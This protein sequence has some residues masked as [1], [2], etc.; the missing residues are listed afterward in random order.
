M[1][2]EEDMV[3]EEE[4]PKVKPDEHIANTFEAIPTNISIGTIVEKT[5]SSKFFTE[6]KMSKKGFPQAKR[7][8][9]IF[10]YMFIVNYNIVLCRCQF[11]ML[12]G[13]YFHNK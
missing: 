13:V 6:F 11:Q 2:T 9:V 10:H 8:D 5:N 7:R 3:L 4:L 1:I 12:K